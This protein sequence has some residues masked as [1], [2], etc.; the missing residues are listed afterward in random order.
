[1]RARGNGGFLDRSPLFQEAGIRASVRGREKPNSTFNLQ[2]QGTPSPDM[3]NPEKFENLQHS[4]AWLGIAP[5]PY[6]SL[7]P[8]G[9]ESPKSLRR[10]SGVSKKT[11]LRLR[12]LFRDCL[13]H[14]KKDPGPGR[15]FGD[16]SG[17]PGPGAIPMPGAPA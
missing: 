8:S 10:V 5:A 13:G 14:F 3:E 2:A 11:V 12:R 16:S 9:P 4:P 17:I 1:M 15:L 7:A 6:R